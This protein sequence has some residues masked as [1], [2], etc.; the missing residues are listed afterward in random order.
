MQ[1]EQRPSSC[2]T[3]SQPLDRIPLLV[4]LV[5]DTLLMGGQK[6]KCSTDTYRTYVRLSNTRG[7]YLPAP[8]D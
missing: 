4:L 3:L 2:L 7:S 1:F 5:V 6:Q 8:I